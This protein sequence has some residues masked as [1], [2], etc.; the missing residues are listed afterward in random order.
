MISERA[1]TRLIF[2]TSAGSL[3]QWL[4]KLSMLPYEKTLASNILCGSILDGEELTPGFVIK[5]RG[6][7]MIRREEQS[8]DIWRSSRVEH[9][10][11]RE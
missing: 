4:L 6:K 3:S 5:K 7:W 11:E 10:E 8:Q 1:A 2:A 9:R